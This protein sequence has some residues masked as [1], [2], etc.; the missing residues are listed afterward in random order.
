MGS[1]HWENWRS[2]IQIQLNKEDQ[3]GRM[4]KEKNYVSILSSFPAA[5][6]LAAVFCSLPYKLL[7]SIIKT[8]SSELGI[9]INNFYRTKSCYKSV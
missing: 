6:G 5:V 3:Y 7:F 4:Y 2:Q 9:T 8:F 1:K